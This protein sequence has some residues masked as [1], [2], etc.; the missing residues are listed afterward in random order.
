MISWQNEKKNL[1]QFGRTDWNCIGGWGEASLQGQGTP[2]G[3]SF[4]PVRACGAQC[5][6]CRIRD[7]MCAFLRSLFPFGLGGLSFPFS[8]QDLLV[9]SWSLPE[10]I[11]VN[12]NESERIWMS[13]WESERIWS[14]TERIWA[15]LKESEWMWVKVCEANLSESDWFF[16]NLSESEWNCMKRNESVWDCKNLSESM[17]IRVRLGGSGGVWVKLHEA[18]QILWD[19]KNLIETEHIWVRLGGS[20]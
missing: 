4:R 16:L 18:E 12:L 14:E 15:N 1:S 17:Q 6:S 20:E 19:W 7:E 2:T 10:K 11:W 3:R 13:L 8:L 9:L 5:Y